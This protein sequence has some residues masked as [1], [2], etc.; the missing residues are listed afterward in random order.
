MSLSLSP[1]FFLH[2]KPRLLS[3]LEG[4]DRCIGDRSPNSWVLAQGSG[5]LCG[6]VLLGFAVQSCRQCWVSCPMGLCHDGWHKRGIFHLQS[7]PVHPCRVESQPAPS[8]LPY[9]L[10]IKLLSQNW[11]PQK[12]NRC[13]TCNQMRAEVCSPGYPLVPV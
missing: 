11:S 4:G 2:W 7:V 9:L 3:S 13:E 8:P 12:Y 6:V 10:K 5:F 1:L